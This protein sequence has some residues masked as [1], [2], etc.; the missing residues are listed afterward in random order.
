LKSLI[1]VVE[2]HEDIQFNLRL[3]LEDNEYQVLTACNG[4]EALE[5]L[6]NTPT[7]PDLILS[8]IMM[9]EMN[10][11][12]LFSKVSEQDKW[13]QIPF[14]FLTALSS[15]EDVRFGKMLGIDD[16]IIKPFKEQDLLAIIKGKILRRNRSLSISKKI[17]ELLSVSNKPS[18]SKE[19]KTMISLLYT[20]WDDSYGP[21]MK[22]YYPED[23][24][25]PVSLNELGTQLFHAATP[26]YG[27]GMMMKPEGILIQIENIN[28]LGYIFF[29][30]YKREGTRYGQQQYILCV[31][32]P[33]ITY[34]DSLKIEVV[35]RELSDLI[36]TKTQWDIKA[37]W[38]KI[39]KI[40]IS[41][42]I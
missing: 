12:D 18:L 36:E 13:N 10:G 3:I 6:S 32:S 14:I 19:D 7:I 37:Y 29:N 2:D 15:P 24:E 26:I 1:L 41:L 4:V 42:P 27:H 31:L 16:Y 5:I 8:D 35:L 17:E 40:L 39:I 21:T 22:K 20:I 23:P 34:F 9:P 38:E 30:S 25:L 28:R 33:K 11:Y